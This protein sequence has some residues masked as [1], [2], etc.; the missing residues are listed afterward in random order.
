MRAELQERN[1]T[2]RNRTSKN[3]IYY[4]RTCIIP[5]VFTPQLRL[6]TQLSRLSCGPHIGQP[7]S[8]QILHHIQRLPFWLKFNQWV[9][10]WHMGFLSGE[11]LESLPGFWLQHLPT[12]KLWLPKGTGC[13]LTV[14][15][16]GVVLKHPL[17]YTRGEVSPLIRG[18]HQAM[19]EL[20]RWEVLATAFKNQWVW[21]PQFSG[22]TTQPLWR[23]GSRWGDWGQVQG[24][25]GVR[26]PLCF[27]FTKLMDGQRSS[28]KWWKPFL[29]YLV[30]PS[31]INLWWGQML[32][33][34]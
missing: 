23:W 30:F 27:L 5:A 13:H 31:F 4:E 2:S 19:A 28:S 15:T 25:L 32:M 1:Q 14:V 21:G 7:D 26:R 33:R 6:F 3:I 34:N 18:L 17:G 12:E 22:C 11:L 20:R 9:W 29:D 24:D 8:L 10:N 16:L